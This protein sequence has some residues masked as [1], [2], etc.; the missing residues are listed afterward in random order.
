[1]YPL[2]TPLGD[3]AITITLGET[4]EEEIN[5]KV[6]SL[7][8]SIL[9]QKIC[10]VKDIIPAYASLTIVYDVMKVRA[11]SNVSA[12][13]HMY[14]VIQKSLHEPVETEQQPSKTFHIPV[15]YDVFLGYDLKEMSDHKNISI[16]E[17][18]ELHSSQ[19]Y[20]VY[21]VGFL[22]GFAYM[23]KVDDRIA[24]PRKSTPRENVLAGSVGIAGNQTGIYP[25]NSPGGWNIIGQTPERLFYPE[26]ADPCLFH[27]GDSVEFIPITLQE[28]NKL[29]QSS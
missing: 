7:Y 20:R 13:N 25:F 3:S 6:H 27:P 19:T 28:F 16:E 17:I 23:G 9:R 21:M 26:L 2:I 5:L 10:G 11:A 24:T 8:R 18:V 15:C 29:K 12:Y 4:I 14:E 22:P 1:M